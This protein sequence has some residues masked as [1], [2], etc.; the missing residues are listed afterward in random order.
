[1]KTLQ[2]QY[3]LIKEGKGNKASFLREAKTNHRNVVSN[4]NTF[5]EVV[6]ILKSK[7]I[8][9]ESTF[10]ADL[11]PITQMQPTNRQPFEKSFANFLAE[12]KKKDDEAVKA[13]QK[14][15]AK[16]VEETQDHNF[17]YKD[18]KNVD[19][20]VGQEVLNGIYCEVQK[21]PKITKD[22]AIKEVMKNLSKDRMYYVKNGQFGVDG[23]GYEEPVQEEVTGAHAASGYSAKLKK[24]VKESLTEGI[25]GVVTTGAANSMSNLQNAIVKEMMDDLEDEEDDKDGHVGGNTDRDFEIERIMQLGLREEE[26]EDLASS[27]D[28]DPDDMENMYLDMDSIEEEAIVDEEPA[29]EEV[30]EKMKSKSKKQNIHKRLSE[31]DK[32]GT[33]LALEAKIEAI[34]EEIFERTERLS[35][36][37]ENDSMAALMDPKKVK[38]IRNEIKLLEKSKAKYGKM[39]E[40]ANKASK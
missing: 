29:K 18:Q 4:I 7:S 38:E 10:Y 36:L 32:V 39:L 27:Q 3:N 2:E 8:I 28:M 14:K 37:D 34:D 19:N 23:L 5:D 24:M 20:Q 15:T 1:M 12:E 33:S 26:D 30:K 9:S 6:S 35:M 40:K 17:D 16:T 31:I 25:G 11:Q 22:A 21:N 13:D